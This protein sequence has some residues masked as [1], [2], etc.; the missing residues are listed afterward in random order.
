M[1]HIVCCVVGS[2]K[3]DIALRAAIELSAKLSAD[4]S[5]LMVNVT[6]VDPP[7]GRWP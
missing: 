2:E 6:L 7:V 3:A 5:L 1:K 4:L